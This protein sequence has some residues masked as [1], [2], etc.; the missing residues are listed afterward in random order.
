MN[1]WEVHVIIQVQFLRKWF[2]F[3]ILTPMA[4]SRHQTCNFC[5]QIQQSVPPPVAAV[6]GKAFSSRSLHWWTC[7]HSVTSKLFHKKAPCLC[8]FSQKGS[9]HWRLIYFWLL[10]ILLFDTFIYLHQKCWNIFTTILFEYL[11]AFLN[12]QI[13]SIQGKLLVDLSRFLQ[14]YRMLALH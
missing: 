11:H 8:L 13:K 3:T 4:T 7:F 1:E 5:L 2:P 12:F 6:L 9:P 14:I 10:S